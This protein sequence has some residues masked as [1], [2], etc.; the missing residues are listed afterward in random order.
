MVPQQQPA[1][2]MTQQKTKAITMEGTTQQSTKQHTNETTINN[3]N[4]NAT[5]KQLTY[6]ITTAAAAVV[7][8]S[9]LVVVVVVASTVNNESK[10]LLSLFTVKAANLSNTGLIRRHVFTNGQIGVS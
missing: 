5:I 3:T 2:T 9:W 8:H 1:A 7:T 6:G 10:P 4:E